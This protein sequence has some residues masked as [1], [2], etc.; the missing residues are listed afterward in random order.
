MRKRLERNSTFARSV[1]AIGWAVF[2]MWVGIALLASFS[3]TVSL[4]GT[5]AIILAVQ[6]TLLFRGERLDVFMAA[7]GVVLLIGAFA[8]VYGSPWS[9]FPALLIVIGIAMLVDTLRGGRRNRLG[10]NGAGE[11][12]PI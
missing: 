3:W 1:D 5:A 8:D 6:G 9:L 2:F 7:I 11:Q 10:M 4:V 12:R